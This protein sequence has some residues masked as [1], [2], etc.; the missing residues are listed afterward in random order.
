M[1]Y[2][3]FG[4][5]SCGG[6]KR[7]R[8]LVPGNMH[9]DSFTMSVVFSGEGNPLYLDSGVADEARSFEAAWKNIFEIQLRF[10]A[11]E[12]LTIG[13]YSGGRP[14]FSGKGWD[15]MGCLTV[16]GRGM[17]R[18]LPTWGIPVAHLPR[19]FR[20]AFVGTQVALYEKRG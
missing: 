12:I 3:P 7:N 10:F 1:M 14:R 4:G 19:G 20:S 9:E 18:V 13:I 8:R 16:K 15:R 5:N 6:G 11:W 17:P 2:I